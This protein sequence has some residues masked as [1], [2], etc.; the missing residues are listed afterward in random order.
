MN[1]NDLPAEAAYA[2]ERFDSS[3]ADLLLPLLTG[4]AHAPAATA[5]IIGVVIGELLALGDDGA[6]AFVRHA[7]Q[8]GSG[9][10][11]ARAAV[12]LHGRQIGAA[13]VLMF[14]A[15]DP[16]R[17]VVIGA[18]RGGESIAAE[19]PD[20]VEVDADGRR[21]VVKARDQLVLRCGAASITLTK[22]GKVLIEGRYVCSRSTGT[23]RVKGASIQLN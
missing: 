21:L 18:L 22:A 15:G 14:E 16:S 2:A 7:G 4:A 19:A 17:P 11:A 10:I 9:A 20:N 23:N 3:G 5:P 13:V 12:D 8:G 1:P 6:T